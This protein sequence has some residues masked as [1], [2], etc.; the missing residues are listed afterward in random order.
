MDNNYN[1]RNKGMK[2]E[3]IKGMNNWDVK[4]KRFG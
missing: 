4:G 2:E 1:T 3:Y